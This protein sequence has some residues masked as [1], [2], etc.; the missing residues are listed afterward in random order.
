MRHAVRQ[1]AITALESKHVYLLLDPSIGWTDLPLWAPRNVR[2]PSF[3]PI[4]HPR[5]VAEI[6]RERTVEFYRLFYHQAPTAAQLD[7]LLHEPGTLPK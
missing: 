1:R 7:M 2:S 3:A 6:L 4:L 5:Q